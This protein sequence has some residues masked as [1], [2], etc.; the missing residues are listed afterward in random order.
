MR[1]GH[2][3]GQREAMQSLKLYRYAEILKL[4]SLIGATRR[5]C[6]RCVVRSMAEGYFIRCLKEPGGESG[7]L[8]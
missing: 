3:T 7:P 6:K 1:P 2:S 4:V 5:H 8:A